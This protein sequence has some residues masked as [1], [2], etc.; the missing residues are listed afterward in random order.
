M[1]KS[2][3]RSIASLAAIYMLAIPSILFAQ[4]SKAHSGTRVGIILDSSKARIQNL[5]PQLRERAKKIATDKNRNITAVIL[6]ANDEP[7]LQQ[8]KA[9]NC[10]YLLQM[11]IDLVNEISLGSN[12]PGPDVTHTGMERAVDGRIVI[13]HRLQSVN[14]DNV[15]VDDRHTIGDEEYPMDPNTSAFETLVS[16]AVESATATS[17]SKLKKKS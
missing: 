11:N 3:A 1:R 8:A 6:T 10:D 4:D 5:L 2:F 12:T 9:A 13:K 15:L 14:D 7:A 16:R 17:M